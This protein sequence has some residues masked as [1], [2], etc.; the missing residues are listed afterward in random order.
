MIGNSCSKNN[1][2]I[3]SLIDEEVFSSYMLSHKKTRIK[4]TLISI[5]ELTNSNSRMS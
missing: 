4:F 3:Q 5:K 1:F 2:N